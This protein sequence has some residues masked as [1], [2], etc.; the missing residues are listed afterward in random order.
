[1]R[2]PYYILI[3]LVIFISC[4]SHQTGLE[5]IWIGAYQIHYSE[6]DSIL[7]TMRYILDISSNNLI[8]KTF[9]YPTYRKKDTIQVS[10]YKYVDQFLIIESDTFIVKNLTKDSLV[11]NLQSNYE[12]DLIFKKLPKKRRTQQLKLKNRAF[13]LTGPNYADSID[14]INDSLIL[15]IGNKFN[16]IYR[17]TQ[18][19]IN[20]YKSF[21]F[22]IFDQIESPPFLI[23]NSTE[24]EITMKLF[25]TTIQDFKMTELYNVKDTIGMVGN[26]VWPY[27]INQNSPIPPPPPNYPKDIDPKLYL[28]I[29][30]DSLEVEQFGRTKSKKWRLNTTND[31][32]IFNEDIFT[33][34]GVWKILT[35][36]DDKLVIERNKRFY[37]SLDKEVI[38]FEREKT[39]G[40]SL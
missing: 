31:Y 13:S 30:K 21:E 12:S 16:T 32:I 39:A 14:F 23:E 36:K 11:L 34:N 4:Q 5:G 1:M 19:N 37:N 10:K 27:Q 20:S 24:N 28:R 7:G 40:N 15:H 8:Y 17:S 25:F 9:D 29:N 33:R 2:K 3:S 26:W 6:N 38:E 18:W 22:L 35:I